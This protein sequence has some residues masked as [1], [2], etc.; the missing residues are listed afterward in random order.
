MSSRNSK[1]RSGPKRLGRNRPRQKLD[2]YDQKPVKVIIDGPTT[3]QL[4]KEPVFPLYSTMGNKVYNLVVSTEAPALLTSSNTLPTFTSLAARLSDFD[5]ASS[6]EAV[7]DQY[8][9]MMIEYTL[10]PGSQSIVTGGN[11][12]LFSTVIDY[13]D[14]TNLTTTAQALDYSTCLTTDGVSIHKRTLV[15]HVATAA[16]S[17]TFTS[18]ANSSQ[19]WIDMASPS[20]YH[21]GLK[22]AWSTT[23]NPYVYNLVTRAWIQMKNSR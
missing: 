4:V 11:S 18:Y 20:V 1:S 13:D 9:I 10:I 5:K 15:P 22:L 7:F 3:E 2:G 23:T 6:Y 8:R 14:A 16:Y 21:Y 12:G 17:G 19:Q